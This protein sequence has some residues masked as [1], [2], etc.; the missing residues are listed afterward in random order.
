MAADYVINR[1]DLW[2]PLKTTLQ[3]KNETT[4]KWEALNLENPKAIKV[5]LYAVA[6]AADGTT[7]QEIH[8]VCK[9]VGTGAEGKI[10]YEWEAGDTATAGT[11]RLQFEVEWTGG[12][13]QTV[14][15]GGYKIL[16]IQPDLAGDA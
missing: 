6:T 15:N 2:P 4:G 13:P 1:G 9:I 10:E 16:E 3:V 8:G 7:T 11:Y 14:P 5:T 12:K